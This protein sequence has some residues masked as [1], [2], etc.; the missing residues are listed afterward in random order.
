MQL[1]ERSQLDEARWDTLVERDSK[2]TIFST[3][4]YLDGVAENWCVYVDEEYTQG[5]ALPFAIRLGNKNLYNP[6]F[7]RY[8]EWLGTPLKNYDE[9]DSVLRKEFIASSLCFRENLFNQ[10]D[11]AFIY[12]ELKTIDLHSQAKRAI[13]KF[14]KLPFVIKSIEES[15]ELLE[16][17]VAVLEVKVDE[18]NTRN[19]ARLKNLIANIKSKGLLRIQALYYE[20]KLI[21]GLFL[22]ETE[23]RVIYLKGGVEEIGKQNGAMYQMMYE[24]ITDTLS[25]DKVFDF[26]GSRIEGVRKFNLN[27]GGIDQK[28]Y[29]Y[30]WDNSSF[31]FQLGKRVYKKIKKTK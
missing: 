12:Q 23:E 15:D 6:I 10:K 4:A 13:K 21:G 9:L 16:L 27:F 17:V 1:V 30:L 28:Y 29:P 26:G 11:E 22:I 8:V 20:E 24:A 7:F 25:K 2:G 5:I 31:L 19:T 18:F 14:Q 3:V